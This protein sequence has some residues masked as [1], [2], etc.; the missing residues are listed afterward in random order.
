MVEHGGDG[1]SGEQSRS[2]GQREIRLVAVAPGR[3]GVAAVW[4]ALPDAL[5][6]LGPALGIASAGDDAYAARARACVLGLSDRPFQRRPGAAQPV[7]SGIAQFGE[8]THEHG[9]DP[10]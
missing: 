8:E 4:D 2:R 5:A 7:G 3:A 9:Q 6:G 1:V 10:L